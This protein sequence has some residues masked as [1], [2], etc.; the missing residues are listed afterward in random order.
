METEPDLAECRA[1]RAVERRHRIADAA[2]KLFMEKGFHGT[3]VAQIAAESGVRVG[4]LY[5]DFA[6]KE[7]IVAE[8]VQ[9]HV[10][11]FLDEDDLRDA[12]LRQDARA[13]RRWL[14][15]F[16]EE[17]GKDDECAT[18]DC[19]IFAEIHAEASRNQR[20]AVI[21][22]DT[23]AR[24]RNNIAAAL[25]VLAPGA[26]IAS[27]RMMLS[28]II[29]SLAHGL[30]HRMITDPAAPQAALSQYASKLLQPEIDALVAASRMALIQQP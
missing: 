9:T 1:S 18:D 29:L 23:D 2:R 27:Q 15:R 24:V 19:A 28:R 22:R 12:V 4:Q 11:L 17:G 25:A 16:L 20:I 13:A 21:V 6:S 5:R 8:I 3:G 10:G 14:N 26:A 7:E 30:W